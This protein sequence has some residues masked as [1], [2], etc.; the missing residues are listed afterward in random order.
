MR[1]E[2]VNRAFETKQQTRRTLGNL[3]RDSSTGGCICLA[4]REQAS[5][6]VRLEVVLQT[7]KSDHTSG[8]TGQLT[9]PRKLRVFRREIARHFKDPMAYLSERVADAQEL[10]VRRKR[11]GDGLAVLGTVNHRT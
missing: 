9:H 11:A 2:R 6:L 5:P 4:S 1:H 10:V 8:A 7:R 3:R